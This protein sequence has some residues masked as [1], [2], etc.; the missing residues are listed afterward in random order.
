MIPTVGAVLILTAEWTFRLHEE[1]RNTDFGDKINGV[2]KPNWNSKDYFDWDTYRAKQAAWRS[3]PLYVT[4][5]VGTQLKV[6]RIYIRNGGKSM[7]KYDSVTFYINQHLTAA[8]ARKAGVH[9]GRFWAKLADVNTIECNVDW[10]SW[11]GLSD[12]ERLAMVGL[13]EA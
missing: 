11:P 3:Q 12:L 7:K 9:K 8:K 10:A 5:P 2:K 13:E 4:L 1:S 6:S